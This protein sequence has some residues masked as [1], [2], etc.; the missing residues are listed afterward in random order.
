[1]ITKLS[2]L[3]RMIGKKVFV[4]TNIIKCEGYIGTVN[5]IRDDTNLVIRNNDEDNIESIFNIRSIP[6][7]F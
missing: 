2:I 7:E 6:Y 3:K 1:M 5:D 4:I